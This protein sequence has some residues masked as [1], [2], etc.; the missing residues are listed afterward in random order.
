MTSGESWS[1]WERSDRERREPLR[2][3][4]AVVPLKETGRPDPEVSAKAQRRKF[5]R[6]LT[7]AKAGLVLRMPC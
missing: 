2:P 7:P 3:N 6:K 5:S 1:G 4:V